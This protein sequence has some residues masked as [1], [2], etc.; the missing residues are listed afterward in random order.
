MSVAIGMCL[1]LDGRA[2]FTS[3]LASADAEFSIALRAD[4]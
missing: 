4:V 3:L 2:M 1:Q